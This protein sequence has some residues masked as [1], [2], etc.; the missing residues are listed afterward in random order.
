[1]EVP[2]GPAVVTVATSD[3]LSDGYPVVIERFAPGLVYPSLRRSPSP[4]GE[5]IQFF[6]G[7]A[8]LD[9]AHPGETLYAFATGLGPAEPFSTQ[10][11]PRP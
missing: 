7:R 2:L 9:V 10:R 8:G 3:G 5:P 1:M 11:S 4:D 6:S